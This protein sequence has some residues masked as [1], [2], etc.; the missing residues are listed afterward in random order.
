MLECQ[1][2]EVVL[3]KEDEARHCI[4]G[5]VSHFDRQ[6]ASGAIVVARVEHEAPKRGHEQLDELGKEVDAPLVVVIATLVILGQFDERRRHCIEKQ[7]R[8]A[9]GDVQRAELPPIH[10][11]GGLCQASTP[12]GVHI[13]IARRR[14]GPLA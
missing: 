12:M 5:E 3:G 7:G 6:L 4:L 13:T 9:K 1:E 14:H 10:R 2:A 11:V 8:R